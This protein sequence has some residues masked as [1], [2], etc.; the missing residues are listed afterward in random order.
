M[1][2]ERI[3]IT[4][5]GLQAL[6]EELDDL[7]NRRRVEIAQALQAA[8]EE[9][10]LREN[11]GYDAA[12]H[13]QAFIEGRIREIEDILRRAEVI[14][15][16]PN[17]DARVV[18]LGS[19]VTIEIDGAQETYTIVGAVE[20]KPSAGRISN[21]SPFGRALLGHREG[22][23]VEIQTPAAVLHARIITVEG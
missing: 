5:A 20:A 6:R 2:R 11:A 13:D 19:T 15:E 14:D 3:P 8:R 1:Q 16:A 9:G 18:R 7:V 10:D 21:E 4:K 23:E 22:E 12:K 17:G